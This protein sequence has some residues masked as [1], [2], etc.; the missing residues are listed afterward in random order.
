MRNTIL[1]QQFTLSSAVNP[2]WMLGLLDG[3]SGGGVGVSDLLCGLDLRSGR[4]LSSSI[5]SL[6]LSEL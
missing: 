6:S 1:R 3:G 4:K 5:I 2:D